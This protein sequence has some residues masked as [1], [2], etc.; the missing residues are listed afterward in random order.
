M[1]A[2]DMGPL[3]PAQGAALMLAVRALPEAQREALQAQIQ[4]N[5]VALPPVVPVDPMSTLLSSRIAAGLVLPLAND[6]TVVMHMMTVFADVGAFFA[7]PIIRLCWREPNLVLR[8]DQGSGKA[9]LTWIDKHIESKPLLGSFLRGEDPYVSRATTQ[10][11][12]EEEATRREIQY[13]VAKTAQKILSLEIFN[14]RPR[15]TT[16]EKAQIPKF[17]DVCNIL[18]ALGGFDFIVESDFKAIGKPPK[19]PSMWLS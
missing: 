6:T 19:R 8:S 11:R 3:T 5:I 2:N 17:E 7:C 9:F 15:Y 1:N 14:L 10:G 16:P 13:V 18:Y 4:A 12:M